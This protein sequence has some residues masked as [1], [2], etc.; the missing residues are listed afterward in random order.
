MR[1][2]MTQADAGNVRIPR[3]MRGRRFVAV[4]V[5][6]LMPAGG[7]VQPADSSPEPGL[8]LARERAA[9]ARADLDTLLARYRDAALAA[10]DTAAESM[11]LR[12]GVEEARA[13]EREAQ[14]SFDDRVAQ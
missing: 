6:A 12:V 9:A 10:D 11:R 1:P 14:R 4:A 3:E 5:L 13:A 8:S 7:L 2:G